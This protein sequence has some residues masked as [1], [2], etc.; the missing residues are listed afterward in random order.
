MGNKN[1]Y[2]TFENFI[3]KVRESEI[4]YNKLNVN[5]KSPS[6][7]EISVGWKKKLKVNGSIVKTDQYDRYENSTCKTIYGSNEILISY[8]DEKLKLKISNN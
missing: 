5:Y 2:S 4:S 6:Q 3:S 7:G 1:Q 8:I